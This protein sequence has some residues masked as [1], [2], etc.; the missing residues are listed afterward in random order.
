M[1]VTPTTPDEPERMHR[2]LDRTPDNYLLQYP[3]NETE[4]IKRNPTNRLLYEEGMYDFLNSVEDDIQILRTEDDGGYLAIAPTQEDDVFTLWVDDP[5]RPIITKPDEGREVLEALTDALDGEYEPL[6]NI[7]YKQ[8]EDQA[9]PTV[10]NRLAPSFD[11]EPTQHGW[12]IED[13]F[14]VT[15]E[16]EIYRS[17]DDMESESFVRKGDRVESVGSR[18]SIHLTGNAEAVDVN[19]MGVRF[20]ETEVRFLSTVVWLLKRGEYIDDDAF[21]EQYE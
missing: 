13:Q 6:R 5:D 19:G 12:R 20:T 15:W 11:I 14:L 18:E 8:V 3:N 17:A 1:S 2:V 9:R 7:Y 21:W 16:N 4:L 10:V